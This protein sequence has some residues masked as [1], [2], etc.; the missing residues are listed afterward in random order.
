MAEQE[1]ARM[2]FS[3]LK[4][5]DFCWVGVGPIAG[6]ILAEFGATVIRIESST[7]PDPLR[8]MPPF[9][10]NIP[11][12]N[13]SAFYTGPNCNKR[14]LALDLNNPKAREVAKKLIAWADVMGESFGPGV[15]EKW[16][17][18]YSEAEKINP[19]I[20]YYS[21]CMQGQTGPHKGFRG[22]G[23]HMAG[24]SGLY[25]ILGWPD[26]EP[27]GPYGAFSDFIAWLWMRAVVLAALDYKRRTG[28]GQYI[29]LSQLEASMHFL[30]PL[31]LEYQVNRRSASRMG[32]ADPYRC[33]HG[34]FP[35]LGK[36]NWIAI[37]VENDDEWKGFRRALG[38]PAWSQDP[39][40]ATFPSRKANEG[41]LNRLIEE[42]TQQY[43]AFY[44]MEHFQS[45]RVGA[46]VVLKPSQAHEDPQLAHRPARVTLVHGE[47]GPHSY[48]T[49]GTNFSKMSPRFWRAAPLLGED[50]HWVL[51]EVLKL[52]EKEIASLE[53]VGALK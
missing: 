6:R 13:R 49:T 27:V 18:G 52:S 28:K 14:S 36:E 19:E 42:W 5:A 12:L 26:R 10:D 51:R 35:C 46:G 4:V 22:F 30:S 8:T 29:D 24:L 15:M 21:T 43:D 40:F 45:H 53:A 39:K 31:L 50:T 44:L 3:D 9:K 16:G 1:D 47:I 23:L 7:R 20:I 25:E 41:E 11:G 2:M 34:V 17:M 38:N 48:S 32:N 37:A 33:P